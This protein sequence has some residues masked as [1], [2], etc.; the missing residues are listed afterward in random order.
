MNLKPHEVSFCGARVL[1]S[2]FDGGNIDVERGFWDL[3]QIDPITCGAVE[4]GVP[5]GSWA[6][7][8]S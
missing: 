5:I 4:M 6:T 7:C 3:D 1:G 2:D 8:A